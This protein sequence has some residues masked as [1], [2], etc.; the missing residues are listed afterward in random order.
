MKQNVR[1]R[2]A[3]L[4]ISSVLCVVAALAAYD[5]YRTFEASQ[6]LNDASFLSPCGNDP[7]TARFKGCLFDPVSIAWLPHDC[8]D[9]DLTREFMALEKWQF[10]TQPSAGHSISLA[11]VMQG[12][13]SSLFVQKTFLQ[14][15]C[16]FAWRKSHR[17]LMNRTA[18]DGYTV[19][20]HGLLDCEELFKKSGG[21]EDILHEVK[22][23]YPSCTLPA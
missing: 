22:V 21:D 10:W 20:W 7:N 23:R 9:F 8:H 16:N 18:V 5:F 4:I 1:F 2:R 6:S 14:N 12:R 15:S 13:H 17:A 3:L 19:D 11:N